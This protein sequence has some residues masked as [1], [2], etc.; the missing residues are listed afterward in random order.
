MHCWFHNFLYRQNIYHEDKTFSGP[1]EYNVYGLTTPRPSVRLLALTW[2]RKINAF[3]A[4][5][6]VANLK[7]AA[8]GTAFL[9]WNDTKELNSYNHLLGCATLSAGRSPTF[10]RN[11]L[12]LTSIRLHGVISH[13]TKTFVAC[14]REITSYI[15]SLNYRQCQRTYPRIHLLVTDLTYQAWNS[16][17]GCF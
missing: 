16:N 6:I 1:N 15:D 17:M 8:Y 5:L 9:S 11:L 12:P 14:H 10:R 2:S 4:F 13:A 7:P 3:S